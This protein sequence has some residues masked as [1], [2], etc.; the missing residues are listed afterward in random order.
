MIGQ[1]ISRYKILSELGGGGMGVVY[2]AEDTELGRHVALKFLPKEVAEDQNVLDRFMREARAAAALNH[3]HICMIHEIGRHEGTPFLVMELLEG[4]TLK[5]TISG[6][7]L[8]TDTVL[9]LGAEVAEALAAAHSKGIVHRDIKPA[10]IFVTHDGHAKVLDFGLAKLTPQAGDDDVTEALGSDPSDLT[11]AGSAVGTVAYMS[12]EQ[13]LARPVDARTDLFSLGSVLYEMVTGRKAFT[14]ESTAAIFDA[15]LNREPTQASQIN[16]QL[17]FELEQVIGKALT[18]DANIRYQT[19]SD[20]AADLKRL[21]MQGDSSRSSAPMTAPVPPPATEVAAAAEASVTAAPVSAPAAEP[22]DISGSSSKIAA[23]DQAGAKH[24]KG[25][26]AAVLVL[27]V[28]AAAYFAL[29]GGGEPVLE[30]GTEVILADFVN[31]TGDSVFDDALGQALAV[32]IAESPYLDVYP[33]DKVRETLQLMERQAEDRITPEIAREICRRR[34]VKAMLSGEVAPLG[35]S[36]II[37]LNAIDCGTGELLVGQQVEAESKEKVLGALGTAVTQMR[38]DL[39]ESLASVEKFDVPIEQATTPSL[40]ALEAF[41]GG[42]K[43]RMKGRDFQA[44]PFFERAIELDPGFALAHARMGTAYGNTGQTEKAHE[45]HRIAYELREGVSEPE[46][47]YILAHYYNSLLGDRRKGAEVYDQWIST[48]PRDW[49]PHNNLAVL[50][51]NMGQYER[52]L[53]HAAEAVR[54][55]EEHHF[56]QANLIQAYQLLGREEEALAAFESAV[57]KGF[58]PDR[59]VWE[60]AT[61][62]LVAGDAEAARSHFKPWTGTAA[63]PIALFLIGNMEARS[64]HFGAARALA[65]RQEE[66]GANYMGDEGVAGAKTGQAY[67]LVDFGYPDEAA[68][69]AREAL[70]LS[71]SR[72]TVFN[73]ARVLA[74][75]GELK[76]VEELIAEMNERW[77][78]ATFVQDVHIPAARADLALRAGR[79]ADAIHHLETAR[80]FE[81][82]WLDVIEAR[83]RAYLAND[84]AAEAVAEFEKLMEHDHVF[85]FWQLHSLGPLWLGRAHLANGDPEAAR[86]A[87]EQFFEIMADADEGIPLIEKARA[88]Y[89]AI[90]G[91]RG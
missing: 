71:R 66:L 82:A 26:V 29:R 46:R 86:A 22:A 58:D 27:G 20:L 23:I 18:K 79:P 89:A 54:L 60:Q 57:A 50:Y 40:E 25:L 45:H 44:I 73:A 11:S 53:E 88:E 34:G 56:A 41:T 3:P 68:T 9:Q 80:Q 24:W 37:T 33:Q 67:R 81:L 69:L 32:K 51:N 70:S 72:D 65:R 14:G 17:P 38:G 59:L 76:E 63:E 85:P 28:G 42:V 55:G 31:T 4:H 2:K 21:R 39:G 48:Y 1:T 74:R 47:L 84:Q 90:P 5:T 7:P 61:L 36:F 77:P 75:V 15:I 12:P 16:P 49:S 43:E 19:A 6:R 78:Q 13:A 10:N 62:A 30:E 87:Y 91:A 35:S 64:G 8:P 52:M 83:G